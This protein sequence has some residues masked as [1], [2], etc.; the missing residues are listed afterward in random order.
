MNKLDHTW[1]K[2]DSNVPPYPNNG[3]RAALCVFRAVE[4]LTFSPARILAI[5]RAETDASSANFAR[6]PSISLRKLRN[7]SVAEY[8]F[9]FI[10]SDI[11]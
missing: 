4:E 10:F 6:F 5:V 2:A 8:E 3:F 9:L 1:L 11:C 7:F